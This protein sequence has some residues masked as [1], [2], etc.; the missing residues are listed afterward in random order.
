MPHS[1]ASWL[2]ECILSWQLGTSGNGTATIPTCTQ[3]SLHKQR[4]GKQGIYLAPSF[5]VEKGWYLP[6][7][8]VLSF[9]RKKQFSPKLSVSTAEEKGKKDQLQISCS[10]T[11]IN[12]YSNDSWFFSNSPH[13][14][15]RCFLAFIITFQHHCII[16]KTC[17]FYISICSWFLL[18]K[19]WSS[20][21]CIWT[22]LLKYFVCCKELEKHSH[23]TPP[24]ETQTLQPKY[25]CLFHGT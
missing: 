14:C 23:Q 13:S 1:P 24:T 9:C 19:L 7:W 4:G 3:L 8:L 11:F 25:T 21:H 20:I 15:F 2:S 16:N 5:P 18:C 17:F 10:H 22:T 6:E 12:I